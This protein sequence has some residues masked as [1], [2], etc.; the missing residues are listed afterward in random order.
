MSPLLTAILIVLIP[1]G[2]LPVVT[3]WFLRRYRNEDSQALRDR[4]HVAVVMAILGV[5]TTFLAAN[6]LLGL[7]ISG[8]VLLLP[9]GVALLL[10]DLV[11]GLWLWDYWRGAFNGR[12]EQ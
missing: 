1:A 4:W 6:R 9:F 2:V 8:E 3:A 11:S 12:H 5:I 7:G 10:I